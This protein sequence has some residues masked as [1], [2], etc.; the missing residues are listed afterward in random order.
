MDPA[1]D[2]DVGGQ[3]CTP[4]SGCE[5][6]SETNLAIYF[7]KLGFIKNNFCI[8]PARFKV[9]SGALRLCHNK[10]EHLTSIQSS[11]LKPY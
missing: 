3:T 10:Y 9:S 7:Y 6:T 2:G 5:N 11:S 1:L 4:Y 8:V